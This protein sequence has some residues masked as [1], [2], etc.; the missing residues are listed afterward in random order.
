MDITQS[1]ERVWIGVFYN[2]NNFDD[3]L[4]VL[5]HLLRT[6]ESKWLSLKKMMVQASGPL[7]S[8]LMLLMR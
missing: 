7:H 1:E 8:G 3:L 2:G 5:C 4:K 6:L